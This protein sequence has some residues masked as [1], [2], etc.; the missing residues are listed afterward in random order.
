MNPTSNTSSKKRKSQDAQ[1]SSGSVV[2]EQES[3]PEGVKAMKAR[4]Y[5]GKEKAG[6]SCEYPTLWE[7]KQKMSIL[8]TLLAKNQ[9][10]WENKQKDNE[11]KK[12][13]QKMS[14]LDTLLAKNQPLDEDVK[15]LNKKLMAELF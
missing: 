12:E 2:N 15:A 4:R 8:D 14:I 6:A 3:R 10:L 9:P 13:L 1:P 11:A 5:R 7:N